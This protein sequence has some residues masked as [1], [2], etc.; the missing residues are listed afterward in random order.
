MLTLYHAPQSRAVIARWM[1]EE[2][3]EPYRVHPLS[4][5]KAENRASAYLA[6]NP[7]GKVPALDHD[8][9]IV[10]EAAAICAY[11]ADAF[12]KAGLAPP[13]GDRRRGPYLKWLFFGPGTLE[14]GV[15]DRL[16]K[17][18]EGAPKSM[19]GY[20]D[21]DAMLEVVARA[22]TPGPYLL[23][24]SF[25]AADVV[26]GSGLN[27]GRMAKAVPEQA[28]IARYLARLLERPAFRRVIE[29]DAA[30]MKEME[31]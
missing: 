6:V 16:L 8:G 3:G 14:P 18:E 21:F 24:E 4:F 28:E 19:M 9:V 13:L 22:L 29:K 23:G 5:K 25:S 11:L 10:T 1:L 12:P 7:M 26:I 2:V 31:A 27:W 20:G 17:R 15:I 30:L